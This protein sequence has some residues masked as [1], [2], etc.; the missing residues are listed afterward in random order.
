MANGEMRSIV[1]EFN[2]EP[3]PTLQLRYSDALA[4]ADL[5]RAELLHAIDGWHAS[6]K[7]HN[8]LAEAAFHDL[9]PSLEF[10]GIS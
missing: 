2:R 10:L 8:V 3:S 9:T 5:S 7:G 6:A 1:D 4:R